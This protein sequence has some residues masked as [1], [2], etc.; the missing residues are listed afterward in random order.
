MK[1]VELNKIKEH[2]FLFFSAYR[3]YHHCSEKYV[4]T[5]MFEIWWEKKEAYYDPDVI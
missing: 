1:I 5:G 3:Q 2:P 4:L